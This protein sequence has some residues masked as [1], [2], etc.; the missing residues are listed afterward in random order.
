MIKSS[1]HLLLMCCIGFACNAQAAEP[2]WSAYKTLLAHYVKPGQIDGVTLNTV[3]YNALRQDPLWP[4][5]VSTVEKFP[6]DLLQTRDERLAFY[7][8]AYNILAMKMVLDHWPVHSIKDAG[9]W[10]SPVWKKEAGTL[11]GKPVTLQQVEDDLLRSE[12]EPRIHM[13]IVCASV[14]CPDLR[15]EP[16]RAATLS[17]QLDDQ[18][19]RFLDNSGKGL[20]LDGSTAHVS[21][22][23]HWFRDDFNVEGGVEAFIRRYH[24]LPAAVTIDADMDYNWQLNGG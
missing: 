4:Q 16:Y 9:H 18:A 1:L 3:N 24:P 11:G 14:S 7:I 19:R 10:Y 8:N 13:A 20:R 17:Q 23:F 22:I 5:A 2:D 21:K 15:A 12:K 6:V